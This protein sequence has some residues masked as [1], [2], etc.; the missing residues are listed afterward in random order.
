MGLI[1][2]RYG[3]LTLKSHKVRRRFEEHLLQGISKQFGI[4]GVE[5]IAEKRDGRMFIHVED[6]DIEKAMLILR[7][8]PGIFSLSPVEEFNLENGLE[9]IKER[10]AEF[11]S[12]HLHSGMSFAV[13]ARRTGTHTF[14][15]QEAA[16]FAGEKI[17]ESIPGLTVNLTEPDAVIFLEIRGKKGYLFTEQIRGVGGL[18]PG[19][20]GK[21]VLLLSGKNSMTAGYLLHKRGCTLIPVH[22]S[23]PDTGSEK[24]IPEKEAQ[25]AFER[26]ETLQPVMRPLILEE[27]MSGERTAEIAGEKGALAVVSGAGFHNF[28]PGFRTGDLPVFYPLI[29]LGEDEIKERQKEAAEFFEKRKGVLN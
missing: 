29:G 4:Y 22:F 1:L 24:M 26:L 6:R 7:H 23:T 13:R 25:D 10:A 20:Q 2:I 28:D 21:V 5:Y 9:T 15:S 3:E 27:E 16:G 12:R 17:L 14:T 18:P 11:A 19:S 8:I